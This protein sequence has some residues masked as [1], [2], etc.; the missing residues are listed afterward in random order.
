MN[1]LKNASALNVDKL[2]KDKQILWIHLLIHL[3][4]FCDLLIQNVNKL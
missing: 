2:V 1:N 4:I 3:G